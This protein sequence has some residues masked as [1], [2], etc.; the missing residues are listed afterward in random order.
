MFGEGSFA[1]R[2]LPVFVAASAFGN[3]V[4]TTYAHS[5][6][7]LPFLLAPQAGVNESS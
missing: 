2:G 7:K 6:G 1:T 4:A 3:L 5:R